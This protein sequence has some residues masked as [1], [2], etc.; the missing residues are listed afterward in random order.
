MPTHYIQANTNGRLHPASEPS[1]SPL[2]RGYLYGDA[3]Y[4]VWRT[5]HGVIF[6]WQEHWKRL[7]ASAQ[8]L[9]MQ[10][11]VTPDQMLPEIRRTVAAFRARTPGSDELY[12]RLQITRGG[13]AIGLDTGLADQPDY[14]LLV[15]PCPELPVEK[16]RTGLRLSMATSLR[17][18]PAQ[19]LD[20]AWKTGN[21]LNNLLCLREARSR[22][23]DEVLMLNL[24][25]ELT[26]AAVSNIAFA[27]GGAL[28][29]PPLSAGILGGITRSLILNG[30]A[31]SAGIAISEESVRPE[32]LRQMQ[33]CFLLSTTKDI[34]PVGEIDGIAFA[35]GPDSVGSRL[36]AAFA[37]AARDYATAHPELTA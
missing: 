11:A 17:R 3:V 37:R 35:V 14:V 8:A 27:R 4:E 25:G 9:H 31:A 30:I 1:I 16:A 2:N 26:E 18:N 32:G 12:I 19:S 33:E 15:Q 5:Y 13:G 10:L 20:P 36:K 29:T 21:Y 28:V 6:A 23:A 22:G 34:V 24:K 7:R